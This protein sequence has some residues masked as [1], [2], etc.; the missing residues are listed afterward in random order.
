MTLQDAASRH[1]QHGVFSKSCCD[2][3][4]VWGE[5]LPE[6]IMP[7][8]P[9]IVWYPSGNDEMMSCILARFD[10]ARTSSAVA[11]MRPYWILC[12]MVLLNS[13]VS[14]GTTPMAR[15]SDSVVTSRMSWPSMRIRPSCTS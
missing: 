4:S 6:I 13:G 12:S 8:S 3:R 7:R 5:G 1:L 9:T 11:L 15:R 2:N 10:A 14:C